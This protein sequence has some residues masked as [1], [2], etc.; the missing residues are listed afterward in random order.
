M[1]THF[2]TCK[3]TGR[4]SLISR[5]SL[6]HMDVFLSN[7]K[8]GHIRGIHRKQKT[9]IDWNASAHIEIMEDGWFSVC[10]SSPSSGFVSPE[11][12]IAENPTKSWENCLVAEISLFFS[13]YSHYL[14]PP[15]TLLFRR[16]LLPHPPLCSPS[17]KI[18]PPWLSR[19]LHNSLTPLGISAEPAFPIPE[20]FPHCPSRRDP[21]AGKLGKHPAEPPP[22]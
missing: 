7:C 16:G 22:G 9:K 10:G 17:S 20:L 3:S 18:S 15:F 21:G 6:F 4:C 11:E 1:W 14:L 8:A 5:I 2:L 12:V 19:V 13:Q